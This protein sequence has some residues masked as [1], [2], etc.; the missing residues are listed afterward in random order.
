MLAAEQMQRALLLPTPAHERVSA[1]QEVVKIALLD[2]RIKQFICCMRINIRCQ[3]LHCFTRFGKLFLRIPGRT[4]VSDLAVQQLLCLRIAHVCGKAQRLPVFQLT[5]DRCE[6]AGHF[7]C[8][9]L[10]RFHNASEPVLPEAQRVHHGTVIA[11]DNI[12][13]IHGRKQ[14][15]VHHAGEI[16]A[17]G[18]FLHLGSILAC[19]TLLIDG[20]AV[21]DVSHICPAL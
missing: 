9:D 20:S 7:V 5:H 2:I 10:R 21:F 4:E 13:V 15:S 11:E 19:R 6:C 16:P 12:A 1:A 17:A 8:E 3:F 18:N 14:F